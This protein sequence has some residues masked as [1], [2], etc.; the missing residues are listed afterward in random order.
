M[1]GTLPLAPQEIQRTL[2]P[3]I[4]AK[5]PASSAKNNRHSRFIRTPRG[6]CVIRQKRRWDE[7]DDKVI[8]V[9]GEYAVRVAHA[10]L[11]A[12]GMGDIEFVRSSGGGYRGRSY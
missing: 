11:S 9:C 1:N 2:G 4:G 7:E 12:V 8:L 6:Q 5:T 10:I 3:S